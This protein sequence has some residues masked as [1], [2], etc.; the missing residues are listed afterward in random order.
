M[1]VAF[2]KCCTTCTAPEEKYLSVD[3]KRNKCGEACIN[4]SSFSLFKI[5]EPNL[6]AVD[7]NTPCH[8]LGFDVYDSTVTHGFKELSCTLDLYDPTPSSKPALKATAPVIA[9]AAPQYKCPGSSSKIHASCKQQATID[10]SC[11]VVTTEIKARVGS[12]FGAWH[13]PHNNGTYTITGGDDSTIELT[14]E[15]ANKKYTDKVI[16]S[17]TEA[18]DKK[19]T[20]MGCSESQVMSVADFSTNFCNVRMLFCGTQEGCSAAGTD[21]T[22]TVDD[23]SKSFG[24][25][26]KLADCLQV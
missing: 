19:C 13:D 4:P 3:T 6:E 1:A 15:T 22:Y 18:G 5:F 2:G 8:D 14:R 26:K 11:D 17:L 20:L 10:A 24:A 7:S 23:V 21:L 16:I 12:Q 9:A 25:S